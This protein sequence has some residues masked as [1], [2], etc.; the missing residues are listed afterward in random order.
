MQVEQEQTID[1]CQDMVRQWGNDRY[2]TVLLAPEAMRPHLWALYAFDIEVARIRSLVSEPGIGEI[3]YQWWID[4]IDGLYEQRPVEHPVI[5][6][7]AQAIEYADLP[8][9]AFVNLI[10]ARRFDLYDDP[11]PS[12]NDLEGYLGETSSVLVQMAAQLLAGE[13]AFTLSEITGPAGVAYGMCKLMCAV[14]GHRAR[15]QC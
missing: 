9:H 3:R 6:G 11:M 13:A 5:A 15:G 2:L 4:A 8:R 10:E 12:L 7:L 14:P 1:Y